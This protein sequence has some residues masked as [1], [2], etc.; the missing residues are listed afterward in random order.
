MLTLGGRN[1]D[2]IESGE[3]PAVL[4]IPGAYSTPAAWRQVQRG[5]AQGRRLVATSLCGYGGTGDSRT[6][7]NFDVGHEVRVVEAVARHVDAPVHLVGHS[8]GGMVALAAA[9]SG[10]IEVVSLALFEANPLALL[11]SHG[12][13]AVYK[14]TLRMSRDF[15]AA[16]A[17]GEPDAPGRIIDFWGGA[18]VYAAMPEA[19]RAYCQQTCAVNVLDWRTAFGFD[20][21]PADLASLQIPVLLVRGALANPAMVQM[22]DVMAEHLPNVRPMV[23]EGAGHFL[24]TTHAAQCAALLDSWLQR[25]PGPG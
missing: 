6:A 20:V 15:E 19:V 8:F 25:S 24:I 10:R 21:A 5:V 12:D 3:G 18:G 4:F 16:V 17:A 9:L 23:V 2:C 14:E 11:Q 22:T 13:G 7:K 1:I